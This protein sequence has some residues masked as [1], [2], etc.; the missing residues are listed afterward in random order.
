[1]T[2][3]MVSLLLLVVG[4]GISTLRSQLTLLV[5]KQDEHLT[6]QKAIIEELKK[7]TDSQNR[8]SP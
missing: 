4:L 6:T 1:M 5:K 7:L 8:V 2:E 3:L